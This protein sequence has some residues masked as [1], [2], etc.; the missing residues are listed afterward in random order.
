[1]LLCRAPID[2]LILIPTLDWC[3]LGTG[4][5]SGK[6]LFVCNQFGLS[7]SLRL[8]YGHFAEATVRN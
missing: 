1:M 3:P 5:V 8:S 6:D 7:A 2:I 4:R